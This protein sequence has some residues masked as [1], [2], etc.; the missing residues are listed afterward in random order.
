MKMFVP[1]PSEAF[2]LPCHPVPLVW[3]MKKTSDDQII[4]ECKNMFKKIDVNNS[5]VTH[6][7]KNMM[8]ECM[9]KE[10]INGSTFIVDKNHYLKGLE[11]EIHFPSSFKCQNMIVSVDNTLLLTYRKSMSVK[12][13]I[14]EVDSN[15]KIVQ[16][17]NVSQFATIFADKKIFLHAY[18]KLIDIKD[19]PYT[20]LL[21]EVNS[22]NISATRLT[23]DTIFVKGV[24]TC[25]ILNVKTNQKTLVDSEIIDMF[26]VGKYTATLTID[27]VTI[28]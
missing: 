3:K 15:L 22:S 27:G 14:T 19:V 12:T 17:I 2:V 1:L 5:K 21:S 4:A 7:Y 26:N 25:F 10:V 20:K 11:K 23:D 18:E 8:D 9:F 13:I 28:K 24:D 6:H 16:V